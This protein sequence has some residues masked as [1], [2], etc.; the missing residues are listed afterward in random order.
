MVALHFS[1][2][3]VFKYKPL[4]YEPVQDLEG[5]TPTTRL[6]LGI[7]GRPTMCMQKQREGHKATFPQHFS[8]M[9]DVKIDY[10]SKRTSEQSSD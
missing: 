3:A 9:L 7:P 1:S 8:G 10:W 6:M 4:I 5:R 2:S